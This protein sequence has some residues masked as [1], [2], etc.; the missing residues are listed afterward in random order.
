MRSWHQR[1]IDRSHRRCLANYCPTD[2]QTH[3]WQFY[4]EGISR[5]GYPVYSTPFGDIQVCANGCGQARL[6]NEPSR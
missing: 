6:V 1:R 4:N 3:S 5:T 2:G